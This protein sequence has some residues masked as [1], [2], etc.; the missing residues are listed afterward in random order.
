MKG[1]FSIPVAVQ[2]LQVALDISSGGREYPVE[3]FV[4]IYDHGYNFY[5]VDDSVSI[6]VVGI[7]YA[8]GDA[9]GSLP[10]GE[11]R[12]DEDGVIAVVVVGVGG[13]GVG[14]VALLHGVSR[15]L[16]RYLNILMS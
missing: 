5:A 11:A 16:H 12:V 4:R 2:D 10:V 13:A 3:R 9:F 7:Q 6:P 8:P 14:G 15:L 1:D